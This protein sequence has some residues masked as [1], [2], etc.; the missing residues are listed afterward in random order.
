MGGS[1]QYSPALIFARPTPQAT[2]LG[3]SRQ[4]ALEGLLSGAPV[5]L[6]IGPRSSGKTTLLARLELDLAPSVTVLRARGPLSSAGRLLTSLLQSANLSP[7]ELSAT[8]LRNLLTVFVQQRRAQGKRVMVLLD[9]AHTLCGEASEEVAR[10]SAWRVEGAQALELVL[11]GATTLAERAAG[12]WLAR[13]PDGVAVVK[14]PAATPAEIGA[15]IDWR[16]AQF[17][18]DGIITPIAGQLI[19]RLSGGRMA[20]AD[21]LCQMSL[22][23]LRRHGL[24]RADARIVRQA[25]A[26]LAARREHQWALVAGPESAEPSA[27]SAPARIP[28]GRL[29]VSRDGR[30]LKRLRLKP[31]LLIGRSEHNDLW[32]PSPY[33]GRHHAAIIGTPDGY[34]VV[35]LHSL[36]GVEVNGR[37]TLRATLTDQDVVTI[38]PF[39]LKVQL[40]EWLAAGSPLPAADSLADTAAMPIQSTPPIP[41]VRVK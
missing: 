24:E 4:S 10:L 26:A 18:L 41:L 20:S 19:G 3:P 34:Y 5:R 21:L 13:A 29:L 40:P 36:N 11:A 2:W 6:L 9:D 25:M 30:L 15:Y 14:L 7:W 37:R 28:E 12:Q 23:L 35:D 32:L 33:L 8:E 38:G 27:P 17:D 1:L 22:L 31:R 39:T 16:L